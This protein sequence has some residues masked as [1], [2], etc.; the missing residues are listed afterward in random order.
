ML[1]LDSIPVSKESG[2]IRIYKPFFLLTRKLHLYVKFYAIQKRADEIVEVNNS[3]I[4]GKGVMSHHNHRI[5][6]NK[7]SSIGFN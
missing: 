4:L 2:S 5:E 6:I 3:S 1:R 7:S